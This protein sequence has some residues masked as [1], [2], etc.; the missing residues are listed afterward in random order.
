MNKDEIT[1][2]ERKHDQHSP[3]VSAAPDRYGRI[4]VRLAAN[5]FGTYYAK[6]G[7]G[8]RRHHAQHVYRK[9]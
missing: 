8:S 9:D 7:G 1:L 3:Q 2:L 5:R 6:G 4:E